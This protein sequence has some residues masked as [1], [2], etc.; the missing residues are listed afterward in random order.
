MEGRGKMSDGR[1]STVQ[2]AHAYL[3]QRE[4]DKRHA[5]A[6]TITGYALCEYSDQVHGEAPGWGLRANT[7]DA[8]LCM[9]WARIILHF[10]YGSMRLC[11]QHATEVRDALT[12]A[13]GMAALPPA[14]G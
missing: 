5:R 4:H 11:E 14:G 6:E 13:L 12:T 9:N 7:T 1:C 10:G 2:N 3:Q 8:V